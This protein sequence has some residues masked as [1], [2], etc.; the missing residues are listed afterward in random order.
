MNIHKLIALAQYHRFVAL[1]MNIKAEKEKNSDNAKLMLLKH[2][3]DHV[4]YAEFCEEL[5]AELMEHYRR[6]LRH[7]R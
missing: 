2:G 5:Y 6:A 3:L 1:K 4:H 7:V